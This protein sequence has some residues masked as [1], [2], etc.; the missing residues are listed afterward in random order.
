MLKDAEN[1]G[2]VLSN[3]DFMRGEQGYSSVRIVAEKDGYYLNT[4]NELYLMRREYL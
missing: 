3:D 1:T 4:A 2:L